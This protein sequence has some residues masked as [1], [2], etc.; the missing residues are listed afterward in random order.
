MPLKCPKC[1]MCH[2]A[3]TPCANPRFK[4]D[5]YMFGV[6]RVRVPR[7]EAFVLPADFKGTDTG[8]RY[9]DTEREAWAHLLTRAH[10]ERLKAQKEL[11][12]TNR[13]LAKA[14]KALQRLAPATA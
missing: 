9:W 6:W 14:M 1:K 11:D 13:N 8:I 4:T 12:R 3:K 5:P 10:Q 2:T 7:R